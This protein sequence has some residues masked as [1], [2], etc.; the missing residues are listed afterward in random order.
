[1]ETLKNAAPKKAQRPEINAGFGKRKK[2]Q[3][4]TKTCCWKIERVKWTMSRQKA[5]PSDEA[6]TEGK[7]AVVWKGKETNGLGRSEYSSAEKT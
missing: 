7:E 5:R 2:S 1:V 6:G 4:A 3:G